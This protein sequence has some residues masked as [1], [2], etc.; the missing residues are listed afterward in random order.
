MLHMAEVAVIR[1]ASR[2]QPA[3][4]QAQVAAYLA[5]KGLPDVDAAPRQIKP[6][7]M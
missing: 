2:M 7:P 3:D 5:A 4:L 6:P 1:E